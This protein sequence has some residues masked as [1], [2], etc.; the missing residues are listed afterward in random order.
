MRLR[1]LISALIGLLTGSFCYLLLTRL[2]QGAGDF[3]WAIHLARQFFAHQNPYDTRFEQYPFTAALFAMPFLHLRP[4][5]AG[6][7]FYGLSSALLAF[8]LSSEGYH[9]LLIF[10]AYPYWV[11]LLTVQWS[12][13][14]TAASFFPLLMPLAMAK[15]QIG[16][17]VFL[18]R[19]SRRSLL[20]C[21]FIAGL[22]LLLVPRWPLLWVRQFGYYHHFI[23]IS[24]LPGP[25]V[26]LALMRWRD[27]DAWLLVLSSL[28]PMR[29]FFDIFILWLIPKTPRQIL[30]TVFLS[31][32]AGAWRAYHPPD[33]YFQVGRWIVLST[34][35]PML[36]IVLLRRQTPGLESGT[37]VTR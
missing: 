22:S 9:R 5:I 30:F 2:H 14:I 6:S 15:P 20:A 33:T 10:L 26:L 35:M 21:L 13:A 16:L 31:W 8:G 24:I 27:R 25:L 37:D 3:E 32:C 11:G 23:A 12:V 18:T 7:L 4:E 17:P 36:A 29:W 1:L 34:Y 19:L 28:L